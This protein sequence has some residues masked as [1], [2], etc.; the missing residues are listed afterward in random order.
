MSR[1]FHEHHYSKASAQSFKAQGPPSRLAK[2]GAF[3]SENFHSVQTSGGSK[4]GSRRAYDVEQAGCNAEFFRARW[5]SKILLNIGLSQI[6]IT[7]AR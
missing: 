2:S 6:A 3:L 7:M 4:R 1:F 5:I